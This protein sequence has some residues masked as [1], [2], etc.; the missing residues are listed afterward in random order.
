M[1]YVHEK[2]PDSEVF[3]QLLADPVAW[4]ECL[5]V[6]LAAG[7]DCRNRLTDGH[8]TRARLSRLT[9]F[10]GRVSA[11]AERLVSLGLWSRTDDGFQ[12]CGWSELQDTKESVEERRR[13]WRARGPL[14]RRAVFE[15]DGWAWRYCQAPVSIQ[16]GQVDHIEPLSR[17]GSDSLENL[18]T[19]C[20]ECNRDKGAKTPA[21][22]N[23]VAR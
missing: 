12:F 10:G 16:T 15:R 23:R 6:W 7:C 1:F 18:A 4:A 13:R 3:D 20:A 2:F 8:V 11:V 21:E 22:W 17:G 14:P 9:P 19:S 5:A